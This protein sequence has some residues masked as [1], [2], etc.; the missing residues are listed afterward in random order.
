ME[1][2]CPYNQLQLMTAGLSAQNKLTTMGEKKVEEL[3]EKIN[4]VSSIKTKAEL[5][6]AVAT[7]NGITLSELINS[8]NY[9]VLIDDYEKRIFNQ[10]I[11]ILSDYGFTDIECWAL[12]ALTLGKLT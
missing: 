10:G 4:N 2:N 1:L 5:N 9:S 7:S 12:V 11:Q 6:D 3:M 8:P